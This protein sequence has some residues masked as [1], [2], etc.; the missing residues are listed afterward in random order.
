MDLGA[1]PETVLADGPYD[2][3]AVQRYIDA[4]EDFDVI[5]AVRRRD[6]RLWPM[7]VLD[8]VINNADR[9]LGHI[10]QIKRRLI[11]I[12][13]GLTFHPDDKLRTVL[14]VFA[15]EDIPQWLVERLR[16]LQNGLAGELGERVERL[17]GAEELEKTMLR[18]ELLLGKPIHPHPPSDRPPLPWPPY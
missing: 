18:V 12:D 5:G 9:K 15:G 2:L 6:E 3:G 10:L 1:V 13:H 14:W 4:D 8:A 11:G 16:I 17:L 7:A